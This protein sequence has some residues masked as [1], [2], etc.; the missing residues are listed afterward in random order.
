[1]DRLDIL[2]RAAAGFARVLAEVGPDQWDAP[3]G[4]DGWSVRVLVDHVIGGNRMAT[5]LLR[6]GSR[7][8]ARAQFVPSESGADLVTAFDESRREQAE[9]FA[10]EGVLEQIVEHPAM[11]MPG[12]QLL[13]FRITEYAL[14]GWDLARA[15][16]A[17]D[18]I[19]PA[20]LEVLYADL[21]AM[22]PLVAA[23]GMFG[24]GASPDLPPDTSL[25]VTVLDLSGRR[26]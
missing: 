26:A 17:D 3:T 13:S 6:G 1:M 14:H 10:V 2:D 15:V 19:D 9:A 23:S 11:D 25:Q 7:P 24:T 20:V 5:V 22:G 4:N 12:T 21:S 16:G 8:E 18:T